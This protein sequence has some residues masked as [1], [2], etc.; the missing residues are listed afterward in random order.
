MEAEGRVCGGLMGET[1]K[2]QGGGK[3]SGMCA[4]NRFGNINLNV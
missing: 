2:I 4:T 3:V 1:F